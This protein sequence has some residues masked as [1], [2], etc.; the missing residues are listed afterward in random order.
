V[1][2]NTLGFIYYKK[3]LPSAVQP[4]AFRR[5]LT[6]TLPNPETH[7]HLGL[8]YEKNG[9]KLQGRSESLN[10]GAHAS[11]PISAAAQDAARP[12]WLR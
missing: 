4:D 3:K 2:R 10:R 7:Y 8:A 5:Q 12:F 1:K 9:D 11:N 6:R